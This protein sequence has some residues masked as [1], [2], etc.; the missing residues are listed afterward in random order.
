MTE[1]QIAASLASLLTRYATEE[2]EVEGLLRE[3]EKILEPMGYQ[4]I[5]GVWQKRN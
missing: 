5:E 1:N 3:I 2:I 4:C